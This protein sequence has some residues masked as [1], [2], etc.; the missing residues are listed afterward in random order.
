[1][2]R[3]SSATRPFSM[4]IVRCAILLL[5]FGV[6]PSASLFAQTGTDASFIG[7]V[8]DS[9]GGAVAGAEITIKHLSTGLTK[10]ATSDESGNFSISALP[11]GPYSVLVKANGFKRWELS[12]TELSVSD[13]SRLTPVLTLGEVSETVSVEA[14]TELLQT[15]KGTV[16]TVVQMQQIRELPL[17]T[18]NPLALAA[19]V[20]GMRWEST[21][22]GGERATYIQ[23]QGLRNNKT[24][25]LLDG[26]N[27]N[28]PMDEGGTAIPNVDAIAEFNV[29]TLN[30]NA[31]SGRNPT[32]VI[33]VI[34]SGTNQLRG[35]AWEFLQNDAFNA[36][37][38]FSPTR[39]T[40][41]R[42]QFGGAVGG[43]I[44]QNKTFIFGSYEGTIIRNAR[45]YNSQAVTPAM[46]QGDFSALS[47]VINDPL[48]KAPFPGNR[49]PAD[50]IS[51]A[52]RYFLPL[53]LEA[54][55][56]DG[57]YK[58]NVSAKN[59]THE[60]TI[61]LDHILTPAQRLYG[62]AV[63]VR[64]PQDQLGYRP[65]PGLT[66]YSEVQQYNIGMS[67]TWTMSPNTLLTA[68]FG[69]MRTDS[70]YSN[71]ALG[72]QNDVQLAGIQGIPTAGREKWIGPPD[73]SFAS[74]YTG[75]NFPGGW[76]VPG[77][78]YGTVYNGK[79][80]ISHVRGSHTL[81]TGFEYGDWRT[82]GAHGSA[83]PRGSFSF[84][85]LYTNDGFADYLL[86]L[87]SSTSRNDPLTTFGNDRAPYMAGFVQDVWRVRENF[88]LE[89]GL[90][91][92]RW[93]AHRNFQQISSIWD[94]GI[95][96][97]VVAVDSNG[98]PNLNAFPVTPFLANA[99]RNLW[100]TA[101]EANIPD[102]LYEANGNWAPRFGAVYRPFKS[103]DFVV[104]AG[105]GTY[106]NSF[107]GNRGGST[108]N[109]PHWSSEALTVATTALQRW[110]TVWPADP[111]SFG[112]FTVNAP[113]YNIR[114][115][116]THEWNATIQTALPFRSALTL[117]YVGT[118]VNNEI[119]ANLLNEASVG[120]H[121]N[122]QAD[123]PFPQFASIQT[124]QNLGKNWY[125]A[126]QTK[127]ERRFTS[128]LSFILS[129]SFSR[130]MAEN[131]PDCETCA[132]LPYSPGWYN[133][134]R[135]SFDRRHIEYAAVVWELPFGRGRR[136]GSGINRATDLLL[137]GWQLAFTQQGQSGAPLSISN[138]VASLGN[139]QT[140]RANIVGNPGVDN[141]GPNG[142][143]NTAAFATAPNYTFGNS[144]IGVIEGPGIFAINTN[145]SKNFNITESKYLQFRW[146]SFNVTNR[147][148]YNNP[149]TSLTS[150]TYSRITG[151]GDS[152]Y[153]QLGLKFYF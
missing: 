75:V 22:N 134:G 90:R 68:A 15:E 41:R 107:T 66:G 97:V 24:A 102:G 105:Y 39:A 106:Y 72:K 67:Y 118:R 98:D 12:R 28:A 6:L 31:E 3:V 52:S 103:K 91:Y 85:N 7:T 99:T 101:R 83:A 8:T 108:I 21:Q 56:P 34:K 47:K 100:A 121:S 104:R 131:L 86:G 40:V 2:R 46:K 144:G 123:R 4:W 63:I 147:V 116:R 62:R 26:L 117:S 152:R 48:T 81:A 80:S 153:M 61:R 109:M 5:F 69:T 114:P 50:R 138:G 37:N 140:P 137:G 79:T 95:N 127:V 115:A 88:T 133:R 96:K 70:S 142:W 149:S 38:T 126:L 148:N 93:L 65:D 82:F 57:F 89:L 9:S 16:E 84:G 146:E 143:F 53:I 113:L 17:P 150:A 36:R 10:T 23:G 58:N 43:P 139:G 141:P 74:G 136:F 1:M 125:H 87:T 29:Q 51:D 42:N 111:T 14:N 92:E 25:F 13:R 30:F 73:I 130:S 94:P 110:E 20:P 33:V 119:A 132:L 145:L 135:T 60:G 122:I 64:Q 112:A 45:I 59:D 151:A 27:S 32:Q 19:L 120:F 71:P 44:V 76:G 11:I 35:T 49:I 77:A 78:L 54:N 129:Y 55:S 128:G 18:R 124:Y